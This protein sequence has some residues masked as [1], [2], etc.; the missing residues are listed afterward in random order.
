MGGCIPDA[1]GMVVVV[2]VVV[3]AVMVVV[4]VVDVVFFGGVGGGDD[5]TWYV[6]N[7]LDAK[8]SQLS[9]H[10]QPPVLLPVPK[11]KNSH[12]APFVLIQAA[13]QAWTELWRPR[14]SSLLLE[15][16]KPLLIFVN[17]VEVGLSCL[18]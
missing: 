13:L 1:P 16:L 5:L 14:F 8:V 10:Q 3:V 12:L 4:A 11:I 15:H 18:A 7:E 17:R 2:T 6:S 9:S